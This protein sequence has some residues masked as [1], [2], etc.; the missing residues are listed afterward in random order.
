MVEQDLYLVELFTGIDQGINS[1][2]VSRTHESGSRSRVS[3][4][5]TR[6]AYSIFVLEK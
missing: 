4:V 3:A 5:Q 1:I 6:P 2:F